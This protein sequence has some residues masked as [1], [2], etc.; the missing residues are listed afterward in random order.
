MVLETD[1]KAEE[2]A[3]NNEDA[4]D[5]NAVDTG[6]ELEVKSEVD[7]ATKAI[8]KGAKAWWSAPLTSG[9]PPM[10]DKHVQ[11][12]LENGRFKYMCKICNATVYT[13]KGI[14]KHMSTHD[15]H[16][17]VSKFALQLYQWFS[18]F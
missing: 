4:A 13:P 9:L 14:E 18:V 7:G 15:P 12:T 11:R 16:R 6:A 1:E 2:G 17:E 3:E 10:V 8:P 5:V